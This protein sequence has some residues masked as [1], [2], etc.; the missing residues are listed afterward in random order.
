MTK[1]NEAFVKF[2]TDGDTQR[3]GWRLE[4]S[5]RKLDI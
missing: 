1:T 5:E 2:H 3:T 4:W